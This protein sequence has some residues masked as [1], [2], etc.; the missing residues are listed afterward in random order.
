MNKSHIATLPADEQQKLFDNLN[1]LNM[2]EIK[3]FC[4]LHA[5]P[6]RITLKTNE[7]KTILTKEMDRK[8]VLLERIRHFLRTGSIS[9]ATCFSAAVVSSKPLPN[10]LTE[11]DRLFYGQ[12]DKAN[13]AMES[14]LKTLTSG[15]FKDGAIARML[16]RDFWSRGKAPTF[17]EFAAAWLES[18]QQ[19][20]MPN[21][22]WAYLSDRAHARNISDWKATRNKIA[23]KVLK[24]LS[25]LV[26]AR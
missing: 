15:Q 4:K 7:G 11:D 23:S 21:P 16:A 26:V 12:Y 25:R 8:G 10:K 19:R 18:K 2:E 1:Y 9:A 5:I 24:D 3:S 17:A 6:F 13:Y 20:R 22:E 14:L